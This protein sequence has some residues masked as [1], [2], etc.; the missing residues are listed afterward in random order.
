MVRRSARHWSNADQEAFV[1]AVCSI[2]H[3]I[4][5]LLSHCPIGS[6]EYRALSDLMEAVNTAGVFLE[7]RWTRPGGNQFQ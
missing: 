1:Q 4:I 2:R 7:L 6:P 5:N 3:T